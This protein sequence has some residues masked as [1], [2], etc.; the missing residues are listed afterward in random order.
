MATHYFAHFQMMTLGDV[1]FS[2][3]HTVQQLESSFG[4]EGLITHHAIKAYI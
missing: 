3:H 1:W 4:T 2:Q